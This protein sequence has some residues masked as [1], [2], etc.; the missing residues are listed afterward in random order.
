MF[1]EAS[2]Y[3]RNIDTVLFKKKRGDIYKF[4]LA[5]IPGCF[6]AFFEGIT[7]TLLLTSLYIL[8]GKGIEV[9][10][11]KPVIHR[12]AKIPTLQEMESNQLFIAMVIGAIL[13]QIIKSLI[14]YVSGV[15][16]AKLTAKIT[17]HIHQN[18]YERIL[19][20][21]FATVSNY[22]IG[23]LA[24]YTQIPANTIL[25]VLQAFH[26][27]V[28][29]TCVLGSLAYVLFRISTPL[30]LFFTGFFF[31]SGFAYKKILAVI[32]G[33]S[34]KFASKLLLYSNDV[35]QAINGIKLIH[36]F[37]IQSI[38]LHRS[39]AIM[40]KM[41]DFQKGSAQL[42]ALLIA[43]GEIFSMIMMAATIGISSFF[44]VVKSEH[45]L[46][47]LLT[48]AVTAYRFTT[49]AREILSHFGSIAALVGSIRKL[50]E[51]IVPD[52]KGFEPTAGVPINEIQKGIRFERVSFRYPGK[53][54]DS[55]KDLSLSFPHR[56]MTAIVGLSGAGKT[57]IVSLITRLFEPTTG[58]IYIDDVELNQYNIKSWRSKL[59]VVSQ[60]TIIFNDSAREN[61]AFGAD[62]SDDEILKACEAAGCHEVIKNLPDGLDSPLGDHGYKISGG[63]AQR[64]AI[65][66]A[67]IRKP[68]IMIFDE[69]TSN[70]DTHNEQVIQKALEN[71]RNYCSLI[72]IAHRLSTISSADQI[73][74][75]NSGEVSE[76]GTHEE[77]L[78]ANREYSY[79]WNLQ[80]KKEEEQ[81]LV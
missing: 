79:L 51:L 36:I 59:G 69:A 14:M 5:S 20:F 15:K 65:A 71:S 27:I 35:V 24:A 26:R 78:L 1:K 74:V 40:L 44:L 58:T 29:Q 19:S 75:L 22:K 16:A 49:I 25:P 7:F 63:E 38:I 12:L 56:Q 73:I 48:Y 39:R 33:Y 4:F 45:S 11:G 23:G 30:T 80:S 6:A 61:I 66:R 21:N 3:I 52:D 72:V 43:T 42:Q 31:L 9:F 53:E 57:S 60:N 50:N 37:G 62:A 68:E 28:I 13:A 81:V 77:L 67:L 54:K 41:Q 55:L 18:I 34:E 70:L 32:S 8:N 64:I 47:L 46:P 76:V 2:E 10:E 17:C